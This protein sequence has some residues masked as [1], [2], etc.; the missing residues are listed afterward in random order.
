MEKRNKADSVLNE[1]GSSSDKMSALSTLEEEYVL[2]LS[3]LE[4]ATMKIA[5]EHLKTSFSL[6]K[7]IGYLKW[8]S[9]NSKQ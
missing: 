3:D 6:K 5:E 2:S 7:S 9:Q 4:K 8:L 1:E